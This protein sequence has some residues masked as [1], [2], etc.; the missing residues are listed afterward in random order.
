[1]CL[2]LPSLLPLGQVSGWG[3]II[4]LVGVVQGNANQQA[5]EP[6][7]WEHLGGPVV[8]HLPLAQVLI[9]GSWDQVLHQAPWRKPLLPLPVSASLCMSLMN[10]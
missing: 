1:M 9:P 5:T 7:F 2:F 8:E 10:K 4:L 3:T 6:A